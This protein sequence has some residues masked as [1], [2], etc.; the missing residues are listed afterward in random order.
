MART[1]YDDITS[2]I[3]RDYNLQSQRARSQA[4][5]ATRAREAD[6]GL[7]A[8]RGGFAGT[9]AAEALKTEA[10][11]ASQKSLQDALATLGLGKD[12]AIGE[13]KAQQEM[14]NQQMLQSIL[15]GAGAVFGTLV[16]PGLK[17]PSLLEWSQD[18]YDWY[19]NPIPQS[20]E[21]ID[22]INK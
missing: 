7:A 10:G 19:N 3:E 8:R 2:A 17:L 9:P 16:S 22:N 1:Y 12:T 11:A 20:Q 4:A 18:Q 13:A 6:I 21:E 5:G 15:G 14:A